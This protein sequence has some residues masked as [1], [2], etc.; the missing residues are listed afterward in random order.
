MGI[1]ITELSLLVPCHGVIR[2][3]QYMSVGTLEQ[4]MWLMFDPNYYNALHCVSRTW[5]YRQFENEVVA[6]RREELQMYVYK[7]SV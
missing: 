5:V 7:N 3:V 4:P 6:P 1:F 2:G